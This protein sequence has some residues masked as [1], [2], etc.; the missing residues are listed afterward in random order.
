MKLDE[1][2]NK[3]IICTVATGRCGTAFLAEILRLIP[4]VTS[5]HE[6]A[7]E[8]A[9]VLRGVQAHPERAT[10]FLQENKLPVIAEDPAPVYIETS[11]L[12]C[13]GFLSP[14]LELGVVPSLIWMRRPHRAV[15][16]SMYRG[17][18]IPG[19]TPK[20]L[21]FYLSPEDP[22]TLPLP[23]WQELDDYQLCYWYCLEI[24]RRALEYRAVY[25]KNNWLWTETSIAEI[26]SM[27]GM[28]QLINDLDLPAM[29]PV[30]WLRYF[31]NR[32]RRVN[33]TM[34]HKQQIL[35]PDNL[36]DL[37]RAVREQVSQ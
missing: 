20:G 34:K 15:A 24:E 12:F 16:S 28:R 25:E 18:T 35:L 33:P 13:K 10:R 27:R 7:P 3:Q 9:D 30:R 2:K 37:E 5:C 32:R 14:L 31:N 19:R 22:G 8:Y 6:P 1:L 29:T 36:D 4:G 21:R 26:S 11:H 23:Q 17:G